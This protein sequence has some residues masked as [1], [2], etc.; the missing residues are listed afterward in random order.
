ME[1]VSLDAVDLQRGRERKTPRHV[2]QAAMERRVEAG[3]VG[4]APKCAWAIR[5]TSN[6]AGV[7]RG[8]KAGASSR[9]RMTCVNEAVVSN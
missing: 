6:A 9:A 8:A 5:T 4:Q 1:A 2:G 3:D 7:C